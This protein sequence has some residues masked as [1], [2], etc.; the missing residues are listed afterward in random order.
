MNSVRRVVDTLGA[1]VMAAVA[2][3]ILVSML[4]SAA[5][6]LGGRLLNRP[7]PGAVEGATNMMA[8][9]V[10][11]S[12][13]YVQRQRGHIRV[14]LLYSNARPRIQAA[15]DV[16][17]DLIVIVF[18]S[19]LAWQAWD[20]A[21]SSYEIG[22]AASG[23]VR[24]PLYPAKFVIFGGSILLILQMTVDLVD[25]VRGVISGEPVDGDKDPAGGLTGEIDRDVDAP[26]TREDR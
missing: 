16:L 21:M 23:I 3:A 13:A 25:H 15:L 10:F 1:V 24:F 8:I 7:V 11:G 17:N 22:E 6:A 26:D 14:E 12:L 19:L 5:D 9:I 18:F 2:A 4:A 20:F